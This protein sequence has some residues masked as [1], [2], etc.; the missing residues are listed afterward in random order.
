MDTTSTTRHPALAKALAWLEDKHGAAVAAAIDDMLLGELGEAEREAVA[1]LDTAVLARVRANAA[2]WLL[3]EGRLRGDDGECPAA[4][5]VLAPGGAALTE[6]ERQWIE[7]LACTPLR[8]Y[9]VAAAPAGEGLAL[10][11]G[12]D[13]DAPPPAVAAADLPAGQAVGNR[14]GLRLLEWDGALRPSG[15]V[16]DFPPGAGAGLAAQLREAAELF[17]DGP[18]LPHMLGVLIRHRWLSFVA[19][20]PAANALA[21]RLTVCKPVAAPGT[22]AARC[23][24][25]SQDNCPGHRAHG[26][27]GDKAVG[28]KIEADLKAALKP[29]D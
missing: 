10:R 11:D 18:E 8:L 21:K 4:A 25:T 26:R 28:E 23:G 14:L 2:E 20:E 19:Y 15:A 5:R 7:Q 1:E 3:A 27:R 17:G 16:Y 29:E 13:P 12:I 24:V 22:P 9:E 6:A